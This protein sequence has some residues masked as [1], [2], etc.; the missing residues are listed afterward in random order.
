VRKLH[1]VDYG[2]YG[3]QRRSTARQPLPDF[4]AETTALAQSAVGRAVLLGT[5]G[6]PL[7]I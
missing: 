3:A 6:R 7:W 5:R 1:R 4:P 2:V